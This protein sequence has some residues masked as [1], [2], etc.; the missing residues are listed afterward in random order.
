MASFAPRRQRLCCRLLPQVN[1]GPSEN[2]SQLDVATLG[3]KNVPLIS[4]V[5]G[6]YWNAEASVA[7]RPGGG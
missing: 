7:S 1:A 3:L 2:V 4:R 6:P 5:I